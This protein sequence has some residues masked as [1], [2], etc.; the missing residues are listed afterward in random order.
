MLKMPIDE[1][2]VR[3]KGKKVSLTSYLPYASHYAVCF[4][5]LHKP[6]IMLGT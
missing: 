2:L 6:G 1:I 5:Y 3:V 4:M